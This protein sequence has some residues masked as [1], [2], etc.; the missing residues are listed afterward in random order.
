MWTQN[1]LITLLTEYR[2]E[3]YFIVKRASAV[4][5]AVAQEQALALR[6][7]NNGE[8]GG[9]VE[10]GGNDNGN[11]SNDNDNND[12][13][14]VVDDDDEQYN[15]KTEDHRHSGENDHVTS[16]SGKH[17]NNNMVAATYYIHSS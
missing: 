3:K 15:E 17:Y 16:Y 6:S 12:G 1:L 9:G 11:D 7:T 4:A 5:V 8:N 13:V 14:V 10:N 2:K